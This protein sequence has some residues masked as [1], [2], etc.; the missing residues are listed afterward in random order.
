MSS[1]SK[2]VGL[3]ILLLTGTTGLAQSTGFPA[4]STSIPRFCS[5]I[6]YFRG[7]DGYTV[8]IYIEV[9]NSDIQFIRNAKGFEGRADASVVILSG[10]RQI[11]GD[12]RSIRLGATRYDQTTSIDT[13]KVIIVPLKG[14]Q[15]DLRAI[16]SVRDLE[17]RARSTVDVNFSIEPLNEI[18]GMSDLVL[19]RSKK[20]STGPRWNGYEPVVRR[21]LDASQGKYAFYY[22]VYLG[23]TS[24]TVLARHALRQKDGKVVKDWE[25]AIHGCRI[26]KQ[27]EELQCDSLTNGVY[28]ID[29]SLLSKDGKQ[30][31]KCSKQFEVLS[32]CFYFDRDVDGAIALVTYLATWQWISEFRKANPDERKKLWEE[33]WRERDPNPVTPKNE[34]YEEHVRRFEHANQAFST[35]LT[36]GW[37]T[38]RGRI[39]I[40]NGEPDEIEHFSGDVSRNPV[41]VWYYYTRGKR[42]IFVDQTG[43]GDY[44]LVSER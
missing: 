12:T 33:F 43:F 3:L 25:K 4:C 6:A 21:R 35:S 29:I 32:E 28:M 34:F 31:G 27:I 39:Y 22:E 17:S 23:E 30:I 38:D 9:C 37:Q 26:C 44:V 18:M 11:S 41:E 10:K 42:F 15:G 40:L 24:D 36:P 14:E 8:E 19:L 7:D 2:A 13:C 20:G 1:V 5:D 16:I